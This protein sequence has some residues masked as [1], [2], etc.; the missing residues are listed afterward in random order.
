MD[1]EHSPFLIGT[2][3]SGDSFIDRENHRERLRTN[4]RSGLN[5]VLISPRRW[6]KSSLVRQVA[7]DMAREKDV[8]FAFVDLF[9]VR[10]EQEFLER[11]TEAVIKALGKTMEDRIAD[12]KKFVRGVVPQIG[13]GVDPQSEFTLKFNWPDAER[14]IQDLLDLPERM[15]KAKKVRLV[16]CIDEFQNIAHLPDPMGFQKVL[17]A[18]W[19]H[20]KAVCH[21]I[22]GSKRH[23]MMDLFNKQSMPFYRFGD[24]L[25]LDKIKRTDWVRFIKARFASR[26]KAIAPEVCELI[27][28]RMQDHSYHVQLLGHVAF[29]HSGRTCTRAVVEMALDDLLNQHDALYHRLVDD[30]T[31]PQLN[32]LR[33]LLNGV[34]RF[35]TMD[36]IRRF[37]LGSSAHVK[38][39][40][41]ALEQK[42]V[43]DFVGRKTEWIDPLFKIWLEERYWGSRLRMV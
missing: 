29:L 4:F 20:H 36:T 38:R 15:A 12:L 30:L 16:L 10:S 9:H 42:E 39:M 17:R 1:E 11:T 27:A 37:E 3:V 21:V 31:T 24:V 35:T 32:Y 41:M 2:T 18:S 13:L 25:F 6:G 40:T 28:E 43:L 5:T 14:N 33:A 22:Y 8:R 7:L 26:K 34:E 23:M 19:Q